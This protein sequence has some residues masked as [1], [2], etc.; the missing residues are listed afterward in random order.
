MS[1]IGSNGGRN[2]IT[3]QP[4]DPLEL[5]H[6]PPRHWLCLVAAAAR[7]SNQLPDLA[8]RSCSLYDPCGGHILL[9]ELHGARRPSGLTRSALG[10]RVDADAQ[11]IKRLEAGIGTVGTLIAVM[12][13]LDF[14]LTGIGPRASLPEQLRKRRLKL[15]LS[16]A[17]MALR[18]NHAEVHALTWFSCN[19]EGSRPRRSKLQQDEINRQTGYVTVTQCVSIFDAV[20]QLCGFK[21]GFKQALA[22]HAGLRP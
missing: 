6:H 19:R 16:P 15:S 7:S 21:I 8:S 9:N 11:T 1:E 13:A 22:R 5:R 4:P 14:H 12:A 3:M 20:P 10:A 17:R 2:S 18:A